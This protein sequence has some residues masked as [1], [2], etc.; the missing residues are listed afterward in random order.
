MDTATQSSR[1]QPMG[2]SMGSSSVFLSATVQYLVTWLSAVMPKGSSIAARNSLSRSP[3]RFC[4][5]M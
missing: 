4:A 1:F 5:M 3:I 2:P